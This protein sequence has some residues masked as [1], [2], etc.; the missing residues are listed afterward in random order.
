MS[1]KI[2]SQFLVSLCTDSTTKDKLTS[3]FKFFVTN[4]YSYIEDI[5]INIRRIR[6]DLLVCLLK[7]N[8]H[9]VG[10]KAGLKKHL[11]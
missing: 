1:K 6:Y 11:I 8:L 5:P 9:R 2:G 3:C 4:S 10:M 7:L